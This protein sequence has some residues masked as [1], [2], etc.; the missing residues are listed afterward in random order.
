MAEAQHGALLETLPD[1]MIVGDTL[2]LKR[3]EWV[4]S[5]QDEK[6]IRILLSGKISLDN[7]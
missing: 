4:V 3:F 1:Y 7:V 2:D 6:F 5:L